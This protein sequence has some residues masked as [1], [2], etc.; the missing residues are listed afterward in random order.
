M[1]FIEKWGLLKKRASINF[2][3]KHYIMIPFWLF[4]K[5]LRQFFSL[6]L[7]RELCMSVSFETTDEAVSFKLFP[8]DNI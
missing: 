6:I 5:N 4:A 1:M 3:L 2:M 7:G 8:D